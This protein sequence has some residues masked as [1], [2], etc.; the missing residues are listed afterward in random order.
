[1]KIEMQPVGFVRT[2]RQDLSDTDWG[3]VASTIELVPEMVPEALA[4]IEEFS[5]VEVFFIFDRLPEGS[6]EWISRHPRGNTA[7]PRVGILAQRG[8]P[9][10]NRIGATICRIVEREGRC[11]HVVGLDAADGTPVIDLKP[12]MR[13]F[14]PREPTVQPQW[15]TELMRGY[16]QARDEK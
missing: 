10:P 6:I 11:L 1:M 16:W 3:G 5:H 4:G 7:W 9:R 12:V 15:A 8:S 13:E 2:S 14:L